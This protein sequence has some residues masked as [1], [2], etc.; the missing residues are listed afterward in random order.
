MRHKH[1]VDKTLNQ[2]RVDKTL[3]PNWKTK[4]AARKVA[5]VKASSGP[6]HQLYS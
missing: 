1:R 6:R 4:I 2:Q 5:L 3:N